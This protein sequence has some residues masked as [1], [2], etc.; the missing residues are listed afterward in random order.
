M[1][2]RL[3]ERDERGVTK[4]VRLHMQSNMGTG[5]IVDIAKIIVDTARNGLPVGK[6]LTV[7]PTEAVVPAAARPNRARGTNLPGLNVQQ[8]HVKLSKKGL[9]LSKS[10][11]QV[12][13]DQRKENTKHAREH[14]EA[15]RDRRRAESGALWCALQP[16]GCAGCA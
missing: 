14:R 15:L 2:Q 4:S 9:E 7:T 12:R 3:F 1:S 13:R 5:R 8:L 16:T 10:A 11:M 6:E